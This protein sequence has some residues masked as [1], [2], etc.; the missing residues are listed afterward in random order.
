MLGFK[1][2][3]FV[4]FDPKHGGLGIRILNENDKFFDSENCC[5]YLINC[6]LSRDQ[7]DMKLPKVQRLHRQN[8]RTEIER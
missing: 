7:F 6:I 4:D 3:G 1:N 5:D 2:Q 8:S